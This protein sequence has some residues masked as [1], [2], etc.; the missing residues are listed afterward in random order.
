M[1]DP[2]EMTLDQVMAEVDKR[3]AAALEAKKAD[4]IKAVIEE[5][6][7][8]GKFRIINRAS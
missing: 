7:K 2:Q 3:I 1:S 6:K 8:T 5:L 4:I